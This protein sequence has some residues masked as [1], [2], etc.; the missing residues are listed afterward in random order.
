MLYDSITASMA[1]SAHF[2]PFRGKS[3]QVPFYEQFTLK[4]R[5]FQSSPIVSNQGKSSYFLSQHVRQ[6]VT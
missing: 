3:T 6:S 2:E 1:F 4:T 5:L